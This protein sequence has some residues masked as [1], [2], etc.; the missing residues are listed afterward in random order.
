MNAPHKE[1]LKVAER[2]LQQ[3][4]IQMIQLQETKAI[5]IENEDYMMAKKAR[6]EYE[7]IKAYCLGVNTKTGAFQQ[8]YDEKPVYLSTVEV[9]QQQPVPQVKRNKHSEE[10][11][12]PA[13]RQGKKPL[14]FEEQLQQFDQQVQEGKLPAEIN[15]LNQ[16]QE[17]A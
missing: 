9:S 8:H 14:T 12:I 10:A 4:A 17:Y 13:L 1:Q 6:F 5:A 15:A 7:K 2:Q 3:W 11:V 16:Q